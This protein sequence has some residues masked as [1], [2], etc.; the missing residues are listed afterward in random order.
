MAHS[1]RFLDDI[2]LADIA[3]EAE[4]DSLEEMFRAAGEALCEA[5]AN[6]ATVG[7]SWTRTT[8]HRDADPAGLLFDWLS[9]LVYL[10]DAEAVVFQAAIPTLRKLDHTWELQALLVGAPV[11]LQA[12]EL[13]NDVKGVTKHLYRVVQEGS[14]WKARVVLDV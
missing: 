8:E 14:R 10:K 3:F 13:R 2:A 7:A 9:E 5:L 11:D 12:Q 6:P 1:F 4:G